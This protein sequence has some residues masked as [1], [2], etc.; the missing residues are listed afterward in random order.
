ME[1]S[2]YVR[3]P[4]QAAAG[5][6]RTR[7]ARSLGWP[8]LPAPRGVRSLRSQRG[9]WRCARGQGDGVSEAESQRRRS[10]FERALVHTKVR[11]FLALE[12]DEVNDWRR[13][14]VAVSRAC[15]RR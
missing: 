2:H 9:H 15:S 7:T 13:P 11:L 8:I 5:A 12:E 14:E 6:K 4:Q 3:L 1:R 10:I